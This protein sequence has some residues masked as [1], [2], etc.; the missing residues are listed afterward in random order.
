MRLTLKI[1]MVVGMT[2]LLLIPL[3]MIR[4]VIQ[5]RQ[6][7][8]DEAVRSVARGTAAA[9]ALSG[10]VLVVPYTETVEVEEKNANGEVIRK[11]RQDGAS[12]QWL[13]SRPPWT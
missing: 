2:I 5:E 3:L 7:Y 1:L 6:F 9:Q 10:P 13:F 4:G 8:R 12:G 11:V